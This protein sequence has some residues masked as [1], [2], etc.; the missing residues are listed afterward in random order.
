MQVFIS[1]FVE[2]DPAGLGIPVSSWRSRGR[3]P[4]ES[5]G[6]GKSRDPSLQ[7]D[8]A[9]SIREEAEELSQFDASELL[10][11]GGE[12]MVD[13][14]QLVTKSGPFNC[15]PSFLASVKQLIVPDIGFPVGGEDDDNLCVS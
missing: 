12:R 8:A 5:Q 6:D 1:F 4:S 14:A 2:S 13:I 11:E 7:T 10:R 3:T 15:E 9:F